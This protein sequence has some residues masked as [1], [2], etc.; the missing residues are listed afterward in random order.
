[1]LLFERLFDRRIVND[2][3][4]VFIASMFRHL[5]SSFSTC[6]PV[7]ALT[8]LTSFSEGNEHRVKIFYPITLYTNCSRP[9]ADELFS[10]LTIPM[11]LSFASRSFMAVRLTSSLRL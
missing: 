6:S 4:E 7:A 1:M 2:H 8:L 3:F 5:F 9:L 10:R 11:L